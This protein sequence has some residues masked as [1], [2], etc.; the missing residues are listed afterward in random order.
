MGIGDWAQSPI[1]N[2]QTMRIKIFLFYFIYILNKISFKMSNSHNEILDL[3]KCYS[4]TLKAIDAKIK[5]QQ[6]EEEYLDN[7]KKE[8]LLRKR[9]KQLKY[10]KNQQ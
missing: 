5:F 2:P 1:P 7:L 6:D 4:K 9:E 10:K 8:K 3:K